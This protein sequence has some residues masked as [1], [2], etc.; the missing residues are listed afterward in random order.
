MYSLIHRYINK[1]VFSFQ[2]DLL[3]FINKSGSECL[4]DADDHPFA[5]CLNGGP[6]YLESDCDEQV[7]MS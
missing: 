2:M 3:S 4:N 6:L 1:D 5:N 7:S